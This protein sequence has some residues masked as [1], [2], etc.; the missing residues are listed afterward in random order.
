MLVRRFDRSY[1]TVEILLKQTS[2]CS[3]R[4]IL[5]HMY[6]YDLKYDCTLYNMIQQADSLMYPPWYQRVTEGFKKPSLH[7]PLDAVWRPQETIACTQFLA[8]TRRGPTAGEEL[9]MFMSSSSA[10][11]V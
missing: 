3:I 1:T 8:L 5:L 7:S 10:H 2:T 11:V 9:A 4:Y 6:E